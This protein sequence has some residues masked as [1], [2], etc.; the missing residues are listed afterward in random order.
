MECQVN[1]LLKSPF[2]TQIELRTTF[3]KALTPSI[4]QYEFQFPVFNISIAEDG[5][6]PFSQL[7][8]CSPDKTCGFWCGG[9][10]H[11][12]EWTMKCKAQLQLLKYINGHRKSL[13][14]VIVAGFLMGRKF[15]STTPWLTCQSLVASVWPKLKLC[16]KYWFIFCFCFSQQPFVEIYFDNWLTN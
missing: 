1:L 8:Y 10:E 7:Q 12:N 6:N 2:S 14:Q 5:H 4:F 3:S 9:R 15:Q 16:I 11:K 13:K